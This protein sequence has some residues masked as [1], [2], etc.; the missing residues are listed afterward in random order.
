MDLVGLG[1]R[2]PPAERRRQDS[3]AVGGHGAEFGPHPLLPRRVGCQRYQVR[4]GEVAV[5]VG[6]LFGAHGVGPPGRLVPVPGL[7]VH[8]AAGL[9][10]G[11]L[12]RRLVL[13]RPSQRTERIQVLDLATGAERLGAGRADRDVGVHP[14]RT[15]LH[16]AVGG[17]RRH[18]DPPQ[19]A[20]VRPRLGDRPDVGLADDF[21]QRDARPVVVHQRVQGR[22]DAATRPDMRQLA[23]VLL[24]V[25]PR[26]AHPEPVRG[27]RATRPR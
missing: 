13:D 6:L 18:E 20:G 4:F 21:D 25:G 9:E 14:H 19:L 15:F 27:A 17:T 22:V 12:A 26:H 3:A 16:A 7:L 23:R 5:V 2:R 8:G 10:K 11:D 24:H 1:V